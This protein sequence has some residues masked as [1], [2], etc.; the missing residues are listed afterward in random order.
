MHS[1]LEAGWGEAYGLSMAENCRSSE[2]SSSGDGCRMSGSWRARPSDLEFEH[3][4]EG[5]SQELYIAVQQKNLT[6]TQQ[7]VAGGTNINSRFVR[8]H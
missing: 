3:C 2:L 6:R 4:L 1:G 7:L 8:H 5:N